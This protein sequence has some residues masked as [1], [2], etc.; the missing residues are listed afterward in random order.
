MTT[1]YAILF[2]AS[3]EEH[4]LKASPL[5]PFVWWHY[6]DDI[7]I[8]NELEKCDILILSI[9]ILA[10]VSPRINGLF[11]FLVLIHLL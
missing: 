6:I 8:L 10:L 3:L 4:F 9:G 7:F 2:M 5:K 11:H 1:R